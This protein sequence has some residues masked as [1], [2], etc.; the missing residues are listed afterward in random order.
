MNDKYQVMPD[1]SDEEYDALKANITERGV[2]VP[3]EVDEEGN[4]L[5]G[6]HRK[7]VCE[8][9]GIT[10]YPTIV[11]EGL[12]EQEKI[13]HAFTLNTARR[14]LTREQKAEC[15][16]KLLQRDPTLSDRKIGK[17]LGVSHPTVGRY[18][19]QLEEEGKVVKVTTRTGEDGKSYPIEDKIPESSVDE[20]VED[21]LLKWQCCIC[22][23]N[24][25]VLRHKDGEVSRDGINN[26]WPLSV[27]GY[28]CD[29]CDKA[30]VMPARFAL[31]MTKDE[32][33]P[34]AAKALE[35]RFLATDEVTDFVIDANGE[36]DYEYV[37]CIAVLDLIGES[38][39]EGYDAQSP[40]YNTT[41]VITAAQ[42]IRTAEK[43]G[44]LA[45]WEAARDAI[46]EMKQDN[47]EIMKELDAKERELR[48]KEVMSCSKS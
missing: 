29:H 31:S 46:S 26:A 1:L 19:K 18:R 7:R 35:I 15:I 21:P 45:A 22:K 33:G 30:L 12:T 34:R 24:F 44:T 2:M 36:P 13:L 5:D 39:G 8:E 38:C 16:T 28:C 20:L 41:V 17:A 23:N 9:L 32:E 25:P 4:V 48:A 10:D 42:I 3:I 37:R 6:H 11:R 43:A 14:Q 40:D 47:D 27:S